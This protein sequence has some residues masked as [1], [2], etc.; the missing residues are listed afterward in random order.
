[1]S[2]DYRYRARPIPDTFPTR[3]KFAKWE[4]TSRYDPVEVYRLSEKY[5]DQY[6]GAKY[7]DGVFVILPADLFKELQVS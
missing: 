2:D 5:G 6:V 7:R 3:T 1:M 4:P